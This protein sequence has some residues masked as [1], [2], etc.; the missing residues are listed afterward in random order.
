M[1]RDEQLDALIALFT[2]PNC[3]EIKLLDCQFNG[4]IICQPCQG[5]ARAGYP[6]KTAPRGDHGQ[7]MRYGYRRGMP[8]VTIRAPTSSCIAFVVPPLD[9]GQA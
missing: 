6:P 5:R 7:Q 3:G 2:C 1:T 9:S 4:R 8:S